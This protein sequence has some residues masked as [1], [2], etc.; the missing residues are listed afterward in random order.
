MAIRLEN[1]LTLQSL[2]V[3]STKLV[4]FDYATDL[5]ISV[6]GSY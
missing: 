6:I 1:F 4:R 3:K 5:K 2:L